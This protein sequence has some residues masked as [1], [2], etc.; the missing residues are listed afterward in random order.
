MQCNEKQLRSA[1][2]HV[3]CCLDLQRFACRPYSLRR[4][5]ATTLF[6]ATGSLDVVSVRGRW[7]NVLTARRYIDDGV[8]TMASIAFSPWQVAQ[9]AILGSELREWLRALA[10]RF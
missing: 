6:R 9:F 10:K 5:G 4:G 7:G 3:S 1:Y 8:A 2:A